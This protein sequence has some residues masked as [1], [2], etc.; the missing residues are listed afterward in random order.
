ML[1]QFIKFVGV[2]GIN[3][4]ITYLLYLLL[5]FVFSYQVSYTF[6]Y[7]FGI[8]L[9]YWLNLK[10]VFREIG[11]TKK[12]L[13]FP[14]VYLIQYLFGMII[15]YI[16]IEIFRIRI[17]LGPIIVVIITLPITF[18]LSKKILTKKEDKYA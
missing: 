5:L 3:T 18:I 8:W 11:S 2:G 6:T 12:M 9:S 14:L 10:F 15:L 7:I 4:V 13:F 16:M 17:Q 1:K